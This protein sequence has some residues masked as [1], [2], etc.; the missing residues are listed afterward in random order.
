MLSAPLTDLTSYV[1]SANA[2]QVP[3]DRR[4]YAGIVATNLR[5][6]DSGLYAN[7]DMPKQTISQAISQI[8]DI[9]NQI[10]P[11]RVFSRSVF[12]TSIVQ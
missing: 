5:R 1:V 9:A 12:F 2:S 7:A 8:M 10:A 4:N 6:C 11:P 3:V